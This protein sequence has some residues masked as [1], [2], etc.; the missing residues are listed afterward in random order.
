[1][2]EIASIAATVLNSLT[3]LWLSTNQLAIIGATVLSSEMVLWLP[4]PYT[5]KTLLGTLQKSKK[6]LLS[7]HVSD[8]RKEKIIP[9][10]ALRIFKNSLFLPL[11]IAVLLSPIMLVSWM[12]APS[13]I[14]AV[15]SLTQP[16]MLLIMIFTSALYL[17]IRMRF[18]R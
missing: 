15:T 3:A 5:A 16:F 14:S 12:L 7:K 4:L 6:I 8:D 10:Y 13:F 17:M 2:N 1:M 18:S 11:L 9:F